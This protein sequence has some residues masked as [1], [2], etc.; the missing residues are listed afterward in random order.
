MIATIP[1]KIIFYLLNHCINLAVFLAWIAT[2]GV[3]LYIVNYIILSSELY[4]SQDRPQTKNFG[5]FGILKFLVLKLKSV[6]IFNK[7][8]DIWLAYLTCAVFMLWTGALRLILGD[9]WVRAQLVKTTVNLQCMWLS[10][11]YIVVRYFQ[12]AQRIS[13]GQLANLASKFVLVM[14]S[15]WLVGHAL[16]LFLRPIALA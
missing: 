8:L 4:P 3:F 7:R 2:C 6:R 12:E 9:F 16:H 11:I 15:N 14:A 1:L 10:N 5:I 13:S